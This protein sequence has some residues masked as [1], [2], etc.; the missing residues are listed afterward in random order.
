MQLVISAHARFVAPLIPPDWPRHHH[1]TIQKDPPCWLCSFKPPPQK[2]EKHFLWLGLVQILLMAAFVHKPFLFPFFL[3]LHNFF[4]QSTAES[5]A[6]V[7]FV[8]VSERINGRTTAATACRHLGHAAERGKKTEWEREQRKQGR[9]RNEGART[10]PP[11]CLSV[12]DGAELFVLRECPYRC[13]GRAN[14]AAASQ[15]VKR[16]HART[17]ARVSVH[18]LNISVT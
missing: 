12:R 18:E 6:M 2:N 9:K 11:F 1:S 8:T 17:W 4:F 5:Q 14:M 3:P 16:L 7:T 10:Q 15:N 13:Q